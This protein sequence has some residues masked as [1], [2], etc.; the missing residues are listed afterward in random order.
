MLILVLGLI[1]FLGIHSVRIF[2]DGT[3]EKF[4][5]ARSKSAWMGMYSLISAVG[6]VLIVYGYG[7][8]RI[9]PTFVWHPPTVFRHIAAFLMLPSFILLAATYVPNNLI[10]AKLQHPMLLAIK[11]WAVAHLLSN[12]RLSEIL[13]FGAFLAWAVLDFIACRRRDRAA[14]ALDANALNRQGTMAMSV[15]A[16]IV[17]LIA[18]VVFAAWLHIRLI[19]VMPFG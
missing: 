8:S 9:D 19:G 3:R 6:L 4:I 1:V 12:G 11:L 16:V 10:K 18:Y 5:E 14:L 2:A 17:G 15:V 13:L 7:Q